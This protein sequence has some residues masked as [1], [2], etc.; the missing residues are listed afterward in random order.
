MLPA[1]K[2]CFQLTAAVTYIFEGQYND[3]ND[4]SHKNYNPQDTEETLA[5]GE[6][7]L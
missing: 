2:Q 3:C 5:L 1:S 6:V 7:Y 4:A